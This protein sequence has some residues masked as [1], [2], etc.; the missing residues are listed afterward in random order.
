[1]VDYSELKKL[2]VV[3]AEDD[4]EVRNIVA[5]LLEDFFGSIVAVKDG[6]E[7]YDAIKSS[8]PDVLIT[9]ILMPRLNGLELIKR[10]M[11]EKIRPDIVLIATAYS[12]TNFFLDSIKLRVDGYILKPIQIKELF[13]QILSI[14]KTKRQEG[15]LEIS[16]KLINAIS[17]FVGGK[18]IE[19][20][21]HLLEKADKDGIYWGS[22]ENVMEAVNV[23][24]PTVVSTFKQLSDAG[25][26]ERLKNKCYKL[27]A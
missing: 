16:K 10:L 20:I 24:K 11:E 23:S 5:G 22:Y 14:L 9:D 18:K 15:E 12:E 6:I 19:I 21:R 25:L 13:S 17:V 2:S 7:A 27:K 26:I 4:D 1:V 8:R 3:F